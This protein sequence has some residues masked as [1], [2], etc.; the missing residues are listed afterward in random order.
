MSKNMTPSQKS[1][2]TDGQI[3]KLTDQFRSLLRKNR[4]EFELVATQ[5]ALGSELIKV[6]KKYVDLFSSMVIRHVANVNRTCSSFVIL[7][8]T[9]RKQ[10]I[11]IAVVAAMPHGTGKNAKVYFFRPEQENITDDEL[12]EE[13]ILRGLKPADPYSLSAI[14]ED[15]S[16]FMDS[17]THWK[18]S[19]GRWCYL[20]FR[21]WRADAESDVSA[22]RREGIRY[23][24]GSW[25]AGIK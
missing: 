11:D 14:Y 20:A 3:D 21:R 17:I 23:P 7:D 13:Y 1:M 24:K 6:V 9:E 16:E 12:E 10:S 2:M 25:F 5:E 22:H 18:D 8:A 19:S 4:S 15:Y